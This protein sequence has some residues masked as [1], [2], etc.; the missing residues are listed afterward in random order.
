MPCASSSTQCSAAEYRRRQPAVRC[1]TTLPQEIG[2]LNTR[3]R[4]G[5]HELRLLICMCY[6]VT[7]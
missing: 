5:A 2:K 1:R 6:D 3:F 7:T 4:Q